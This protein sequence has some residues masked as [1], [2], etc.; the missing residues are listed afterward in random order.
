LEAMAA[1]T[2][3]VAS[4]IPGIDEQIV[5]GETGLLHPV[6]NIGLIAQHIIQVLENPEFAAHISEAANRVVRQNYDWAVIG[7]QTERVLE[8][9]VA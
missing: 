2:P 4:N 5:S 3:V 6:G 1:G 9:V 7:E 8:S